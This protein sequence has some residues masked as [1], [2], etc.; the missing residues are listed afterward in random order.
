MRMAGLEPA[1]CHHRQILSLLRLPFRHIRA[2]DYIIIHFCKKQALFLP[3]NKQSLPSFILTQTYRS[4]ITNKKNYGPQPF[5]TNIYNAT[6]QNANYRT[7]LWTE[8]H[9]QLTL[10][11][12]PIC[13]EIGLEVHPETD[14]APKQ[15]QA[16]QLHISTCPEVSLEKY[17]Y[18]PF[19]PTSIEE[20]SKHTSN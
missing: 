14:Y 12:I 7:A 1:R 3:D 13:G 15:V 19:I 18:L 4:H 6:V 16:E 2:L 8:Q 11:C 10:M 5:V 20:F 17:A 9:L